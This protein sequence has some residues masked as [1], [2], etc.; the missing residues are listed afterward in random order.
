[1]WCC[2]LIMCLC[3]LI[4][5]RTIFSHHQLYFS[6]LQLSVF[7]NI[8]KP[9]KSENF[10]VSTVPRSACFAVILR[11]TF[12]SL[13]KTS[14]SADVLSSIYFVMRLSLKKQATDVN[15]LKCYW[16]KMYPMAF[17]RLSPLSPPCEATFPQTLEGSGEP[18]VPKPILE[19]LVS[20]SFSLFP[21]IPILTLRWFGRGCT[22]NPSRLQCCCSE[23]CD[24]KS[25]FHRRRPNEVARYFPSAISE[26]R[27]LTCLLIIMKRTC[28]PSLIARQILEKCVL[29]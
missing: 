21:R 7:S 17:R 9:L 15:F 8:W 27:E 10:V 19:S 20:Q 11:Y 29:Q 13:W 5:E 23:V 1:M 22:L 2:S 3:C 24:P 6:V 28:W 4:K 14:T 18:S 25:V 26:F 12:F 16:T